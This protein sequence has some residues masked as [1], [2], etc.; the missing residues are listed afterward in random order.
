V[1]KPVSTPVLNAAISGIPNR[2][3]VLDTAAFIGRI[4]FSQYGS[5]YYT[6]PEVLKE[7]RDGKAR[8]FLESL[9]IT[10]K[11]RE[12]STQAYA[13]VVEFSKKTGDFPT[14]SKVDLKVLALAYMLEVEVKGSAD[15]LRTTPITA[16][17]QSSP[18][19]TQ[20]FLPKSGA[21]ASATSTSEPSRASDAPSS[22]GE[23]ASSSAVT[24]NVVADE[25]FTDEDD[26]DSGDEH[27]ELVGFGY[28]DSDDDEDGWIGT[29][30]IKEYT[31]AYQGREEGALETDKDV[32]VSCLT[33]DFAMQNV[34]LQLGLHLTS[35]NGVTIKRLQQ[36]ILR[37]FA[38]FRLCRDMTKLFCPTCGN[39]TL[40]RVQCS[41]GAD[42]QVTLSNVRPIT[43]TRGT[44]YGIPKPKGGHKAKNLILS[45]NA[46]PG[47]AHRQSSA[48]S[49]RD[50]DGGFA[51]SRSAAHHQSV[52]IGYGRKN[53]NES[54]SRSGKRKKRRV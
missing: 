10:I 51:S 43:S 12:P 17:I 48:E 36:W 11:T 32:R 16:D 42:G 9:P 22:N 30:N 35:S 47:H 26:T 8:A 40:Q 2:K 24:A 39:N 13:A 44:I 27:G 45:P 3:L 31:K 4:Q 6:I 50:L 7:V 15:H 52:V 21:E 34:L 14:L 54:K 38:C 18:A 20:I 53:P 28:F 46:I 19:N 5:E 1:K 33:S 23:T 41:V 29:E 37:C 25:D 49:Y